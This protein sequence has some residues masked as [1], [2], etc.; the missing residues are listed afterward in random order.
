ML[1]LGAMLMSVS[2]MDVNGT[3]TTSMVT[4]S[5]TAANTKSIRNACAA[6]AIDKRETSII[7]ASDANAAAIKNSLTN[8]K[9]GLI[10][11]YT[12]GKTEGRK[13]ERKAVWSAF[14]SSTRSAMNDMRTARKSAWDNFQK[15]MRACGIKSNNEKM[16]TMTVPIAY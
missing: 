13:D 2:A 11:L 10:K 7:S 6:A 16:E 15:D 4:S 9:A 1:S 3:M 8:R 14:S 12:E 5:S